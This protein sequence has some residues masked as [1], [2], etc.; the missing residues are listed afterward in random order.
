MNSDQIEGL[1][2]QLKKIKKDFSFKLFADLSTAVGITYFYFTYGDLS[3]RL[4]CWI[5]LTC[6][7]FNIISI[8]S[9]INQ[10]R[11]IKS[12]ESDL[13]RYAES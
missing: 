2:V 11:N 10:R 1:L 3:K 12:I 7:Q 13:K 9:L 6:V 5:A 8:G 4:D